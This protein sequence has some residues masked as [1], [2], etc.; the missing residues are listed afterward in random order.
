MRYISSMTTTQTVANSPSP[1]RRIAA[2]IRAEA[3]RQGMSLRRLSLALG[4]SQP[5]VT[6][7]ISMTADVDMTFEELDDIARALSV[8]VGTLLAAA[9]YA[10][11]GSTNRYF[12]TLDL[13]TAA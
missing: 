2:E 9:D 4:K 8:S 7:R 11:A 5:W 3:A 12:E 1:S 13:P 6:R 10:G